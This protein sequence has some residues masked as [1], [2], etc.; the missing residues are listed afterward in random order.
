MKVEQWNE[1]PGTMAKSATDIRWL[2]IFIENELIRLWMGFSS[3]GWIVED[4]CR[5]H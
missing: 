1:H 4:N 2:S 5:L 3:E